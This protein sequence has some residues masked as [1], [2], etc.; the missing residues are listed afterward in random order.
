VVLYRP[1]SELDDAV[2]RELA[3]AMASASAMIPTIRRLRAGLRMT[4]PAYPF[5]PFPDLPYIAVIEFDDRAGLNA[6]LA[7]PFHA[8]LAQLFVATTEAALVY[9]YEMFEGAAVAAL[10][11]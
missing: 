7:H 3:D 2:K 11:A 6:Y 1:K 5:E 4:G 10:G 9:D 8:R